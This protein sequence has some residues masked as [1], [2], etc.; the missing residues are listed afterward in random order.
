[1]LKH[2][3]KTDRRIEVSNG[4]PL[5]TAIA[6]EIR[7]L[8]A[9]DS[10]SRITVATPSF[11][12]AFF[13]RRAV[14][15]ALCEG[16]GHRGG[17]L[18]NIEFMRIEDVAAKLFETEMSTVSK[19]VMSQLLASE[20]IYQALS[21]LST[22]GPLSDHA[23]NPSTV[24]SVGRTLHELALLDS[25]AEK[26]LLK[27]MDG[28]RSGIYPQLLEVQRKYAKSA[29]RYT[30]R[31][32]VAST[33]AD[34]AKRNPTTLSSALGRNQILV[35]VQAV[36]DS[37]ACLWT[38]LEGA[39]S[40]VTLAVAPRHRNDE[41]NVVDDAKSVRTRF[42]STMSTTDEPRALIRNIM[43]DARD[44]V[45]FGEMAVFYPSRDYASRIG[46]ALRFADIPSC[47]PSSKR[48]SDTPAG[49]FVSLFLKMVS[50]EMRRDA[51]TA[52]TSSSPVIDPETGDRVPT[53]P[54]EAASR[55]AN[56]P[57][58]DSNTEWERPLK[59]YAGRMKYYARRAREAPDDE[60]KIGPDAFEAAAYSA[61]RMSD[62]L[63]DLLP[64]VD[65]EE[66]GRWADYA[67]WLE[68]IV[69][70]Y[71]LADDSED[72]ELD[73]SEQIRSL[74]EQVRGLD[75]VTG[76][77]IGFDR[78]TGAVQD[79][80]RDTLG[81]LTGLG[82]SVLVAPLSAGVGS[83]F[84]RVHI[85]GMA[86][87]SLPRP[88][89]AD[90]LLSDRTRRYLDA[91]GSVLPTKRDQ[92]E[93]MH[94]Q[95][96][97]ALDAAPLRRMYWNKAL[98]G[99]TNESY[100]S[101]WFVDELLEENGETGRSSKSLMDPQSDVVEPVTPL[102]DFG[103][104]ELDI[105][106]RY[107][108]DLLNVSIAACSEKSRRELLIDPRN[109]A[110]AAGVA[111]AM[112]RSS[113]DFGAYDGNIFPMQDMPFRSGVTS[114]SA[115][116]SYAE[117]PYRYFLSQV[118]NVEERIDPEDS[119]VLSAL[120]K[121]ILVH[122]ILER[123]L[124][125]CGPDGTEKRLSRLHKIANE[126]FDDFFAREFIGYRE[127]FDLEKAQLLRQLDEWHR[128]D[129]DVLL[130]FDGEMMPE[131]AFGYDNED[132][133]GRMELSSGFSFQ[134]RGKIDLIAVAESGD[135]A[136]VLDFKTGNSSSYTD[137]DKDVTAAG[138]KLQPAV[139]SLVASRLL[140]GEANVSSAYW[141]VFQ[142]GSGRLRPKQPMYLEDAQDRL[143]FALD[144]IVG[145][146]RQGIFPAR[147]G[148]RDTYRNG[149]PWKNCKHCAYSDVCTADRLVAW[150]RK[151][152]G[153]ELK[154]Y[155]G[156]AEDG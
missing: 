75:Q 46:D 80:L 153:E 5:V 128:A 32:E 28:R 99:A 50:D 15:E 66:T 125:E 147:P 33:A 10:L 116:Q 107:E 86:E 148:E 122:K 109:G 104:S 117:C 113:A 91:D 83:A 36:P 126:V 62:F 152:S 118:L 68:E 84:K 92:Q 123:F 154:A 20:L 53:V 119:L 49:R 43:A 151:K 115:L 110:L 35:R 82:S 58:F 90:P 18:F 42:Y 8:R 97:M 21:D 93:S 150:N 81:H 102:A 51:F 61:F 127:I 137:L 78:F 4:A 140:G 34:I 29:S 9:N 23:Q 130:D 131:K 96:K 143:T 22:R 124:G 74:L 54:W 47:G 73:G 14:T 79:L 3:D 30:T 55:N 6:N 13:L 72:D 24:A 39:E 156:M 145:G 142:R 77:E 38:A 134:M 146:I 37:Y 111:L 94:R 85:V 52:W 27:L 70:L 1:M 129:L 41:D 89:A 112:A 7:Q 67:D 16:T 133:S 149:P 100:P 56:I 59:R 135:R 12:S 63:S 121:G 103:S 87:G 106:S 98:I 114:V 40:S 141:F 144:V 64:R 48:L 57:R 76:S 101:P 136:L 2:T 88:A 105:S 138:T 120:D 132:A 69:S 17:G 65:V 155:V 60:Q 25:G 95:F 45:R 11:Y 26:S 31:E 71:F 139:Y 19:P 108:F 44:G